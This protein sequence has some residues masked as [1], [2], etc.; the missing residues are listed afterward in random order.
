LSQ[1]PPAQPS[2]AGQSIDITNTTLRLTG[3][4]WWHASDSCCEKTL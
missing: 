3:R 2:V 1:T 4:T